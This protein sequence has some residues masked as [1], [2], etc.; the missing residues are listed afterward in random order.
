MDNFEY[1][2]STTA[3]QFYTTG[4]SVARGKLWNDSENTIKFVSPFLSFSKERR[5]RWSS[6]YWPENDENQLRVAK[7]GRSEVHE[8]ARR[9]SKLIDEEEKN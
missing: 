8:E 6:I 9:I 7:K 1:R 4:N 3:N 5:F 2:P